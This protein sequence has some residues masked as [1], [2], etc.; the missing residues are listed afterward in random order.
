MVAGGVDVDAGR[1]RIALEPA[2]P[3]HRD[4]RLPRAVGRTGVQ[5]GERGGTDDA[6]GLHAVIDLELAYGA[7]E[8][9]RIALGRRRAL[10]RGSDIAARRERGGDRRQPR[11]AAAGLIGLP[12][13]IGAFAAPPAC[14][15]YR[16]CAC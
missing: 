12:S 13:G 3:L 2:Q 14:L 15:R 11:I 4:R 8:R 7:G 6:V 1:R 16:R 9:A 10:L 5:R